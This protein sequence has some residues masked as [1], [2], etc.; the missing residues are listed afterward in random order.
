MTDSARMSTNEMSD[1]QRAAVGEANY[2]PAPPTPASQAP[3]FQP[4]YRPQPYYQQPSYQQPPY[5]QAVW[6]QQPTQWP[7]PASPGPRRWHR[8]SLLVAAVALLA[9]LALG[10]LGLQQLQASRTPRQIVQRYFAALA[11]GQAST[12]LDFAAAPPR[13][14]YLTDTMLREQL[15]VARIDHVRVTNVAENGGNAIAGV[16]YTLGFKAGLQLVHDQVPLVRHGSSWRLAKVAALVSLGVGTTGAD[17]ATLA[18]GKLP[19]G[20]TYLFPGALPV[21]ASPAAVQVQGQPAVRL[22][23][24]GQTIAFSVALTD[25]AKASVTAALQRA[26]T[27]CLTGSSKDAG[28]PEV[29]DSR[30]VPGSLRAAVGPITGGVTI[31]LDSAGNGEIAISGSVTVHGSWKVWDFNNQMVSRSGSTDLS[32]R[33]QSSVAELNTIY[34]A[35]P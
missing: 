16:T 13:G 21:T 3:S 6:Y 2:A 31:G 10:G 5:Q 8:R 22:A 20:S 17:R 26:L 9:A 23:D 1:E 30:P 34:W 28:C 33:A 15:A 35:G 11:A 32:I 4:P 7:P 25:R 27:A 19:S 29:D 12:A 14:P 18:G 24:D